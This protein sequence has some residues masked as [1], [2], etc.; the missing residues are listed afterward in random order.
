RAA[1]GA[2][3]AAAGRDDAGDDATTAGAGE[4][5]GQHPGAERQMKCVF[6]AVL[7]VAA[8]ARA[9]ETGDKVWQEGM[10]LYEVGDWS[11]AV[12][13]FEEAYRINPA[14]NILFNLGQAHRKLKDY[15]KALFY[16]RTYLRNK[17]A[18]S[19]R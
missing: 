4:G 13:K 8:V 2:R 16:F 18:A 15:E 12:Q 5:Q 19:N 17:P 11:A 3:D 7:M 1:S 10:R 14:P 9:D 6:F